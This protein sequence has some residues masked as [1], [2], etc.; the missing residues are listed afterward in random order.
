MIMGGHVF[1]CTC[2]NTHI[3][4]HV[5]IG[6]SSLYRDYTICMMPSVDVCEELVF[7]NTSRKAV[8]LLYW[9]GPST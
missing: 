6:L 8:L 1:V 4:K 2:V 3:C 9:P 5:S 7:L